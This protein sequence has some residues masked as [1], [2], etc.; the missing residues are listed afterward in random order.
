MAELLRA[1]DE[2][3]PGRPLTEP[4][5][6]AVSG[7]S[8]PIPIRPSEEMLGPER[9]LPET[10]AESPMGR[11][12]HTVR[13]SAPDGRSANVGQRVGNVLGAVSQRVRELPHR[14]QERVE[15]LKD[16]IAE[17]SR[18]GGS[19]LQER[20][21]EW[22][23]TARVQAYR[24]RNRTQEYSRRNP[25][26]FVAGVAATGFAIGFLLRMWRDE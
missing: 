21:Q 11:W 4:P 7:G 3:L 9:Q 1:N 15:D 5:S 14:L 8:D 26:Q 6:S 17:S 18:S 12:P 24:L 20:A 25:L 22:R 13:T 2:P 16:R 10:V 23:R 19:N